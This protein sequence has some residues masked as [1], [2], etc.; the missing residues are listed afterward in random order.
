MQAIINIDGASRGNPGPAAIG[1]VIRDEQKKVIAH[2]SQA[3]GHATNNQAEYRAIIA[4]LEKA[5]SLGISEVEIRSDSELL[6]RQ[7]TGRYKVKS[8]G[9][10][11]LY[12][13]AKQLQSR[14]RSF[15]ITHI[16]REENKEAD[17]LA[18]KALRA[19]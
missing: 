16:P 5:V 17:G 15:T 18:N 19:K 6:V 8:A 10:I 2:I 14:M 13:K 9:L 7:I 12:T 3:I 4:A 11:P 1:V